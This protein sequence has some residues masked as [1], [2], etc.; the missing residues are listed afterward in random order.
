MRSAAGA[1]G[2]NMQASVLT[3]PSWHTLLS[4][5]LHL[6]AIFWHTPSSCIEA[7][8]LLGCL[9]SLC[10]GQSASCFAWVRGRRLFIS[11][12]SLSPDIA[13]QVARSLCRLYLRDQ[14]VASLVSNLVA[15]LD[16]FLAHIGAPMAVH[17]WRDLSADCIQESRELLCLGS[18]F[19]YCAVRVCCP[20]LSCVVVRVCSLC[21]RTCLSGSESKLEM[22]KKRSGHRLM[23]WILNRKVLTCPTTAMA[24]QSHCLKLSL[25][26]VCTPL[27]S[28]QFILP[29][30][31]AC[32]QCAG[33]PV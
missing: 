18:F 32:S 15:F 1:R 30:L 13:P 9:C 28:P 29:S 4:R 10:M 27:S 25:K 7:P 33:C 23:R 17:C 24:G 31:S 6:M 22:A 26:K 20:P 3:W 2:C 21:M 5:M 14:A 12:R 8:P 16:F 11:C 19:F